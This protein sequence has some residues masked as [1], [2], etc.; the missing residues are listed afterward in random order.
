[1]GPEVIDSESAV[2][3]SGIWTQ[4]ARGRGRPRYTFFAAA[5][6]GRRKFLRTG[7]GGEYLFERRKNQALC[8][9]WLALP[10]AADDLS[11]AGLSP[12]FLLRRFR[13]PRAAPA[14]AQFRSVRET[15]SHL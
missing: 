3:T 8:L 13:A 4:S 6:R 11:A 7:S 2:F 9:V 1:M 14:A 15:R 10:L 12:D 5:L